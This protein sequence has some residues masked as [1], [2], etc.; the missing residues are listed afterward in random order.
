MIFRV[1][2]AMCISNSIYWILVI[3]NELIEYIFWSFFF[4]VT[5]KA[6]HLRPDPKL[7]VQECC[8]KVTILPLRLNIDQDSLLFLL[9][10]S[11]EVSGIAKE[12]GMSEQF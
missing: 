5:I 7:N 1:L 10:F 3:D 9:N 12:E 6:V 8:L 4:Q 2:E 11:N